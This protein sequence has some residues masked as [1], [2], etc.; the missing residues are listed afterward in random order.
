VLAENKNAPLNSGIKVVQYTVS[1]LNAMASTKQGRDYLLPKDSQ[2]EYGEHMT[3]L[4]VKR[5]VQIFSKEKSD[6]LLRQYSIG[7][8]QKF[9]LRSTAQILLIDHEIISKLV[10]L[11]RLEYQTI[12]D[13]SLECSMAMLMNLSL[14]SKGK[15]KMEKIHTILV[16]FLKGI[17]MSNSGQII[18]YATGI[19]FSIVSNKTVRE[20]IRQTNL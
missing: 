17:L 12:S 6:T 18:I 19:L 20:F 10:N 8:L 13:Y 3:K 1:L 9:S 15:D 16:P 5:L 2:I 14:R 4:L 11:I 7:V